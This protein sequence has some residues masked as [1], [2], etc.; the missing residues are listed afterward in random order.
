MQRP[1]VLNIQIHRLPP[2]KRL[3][4][5]SL[6]LPSGLNGPGTPGYLCNGHLHTLLDH[7]QED[8][9][10]Q[11]RTGL[12]PG[13]LSFFAVATT[14]LVT[15]SIL[16]WNYSET[17]QRRLTK[18]PNLILDHWGKKGPLMDK[19]Q[20]GLLDGGLVYYGE[21]ALRYMICKATQKF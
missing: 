8:Q 18:K 2:L 21:T 3:S 11:Y 16:F 19:D 17:R 5:I 13:L 15:A 12:C 14:L 1:S 7:E 6:S 4:N 10:R 9:A 20:L